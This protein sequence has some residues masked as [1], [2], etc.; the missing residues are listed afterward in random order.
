[1]AHSMNGDYGRNPQTELHPLHPQYQPPART[2]VSLHPGY[3]YSPELPPS[4]RTGASPLDTRAVTPPSLSPSGRQL[5]QF[6]QEIS[7]QRH[8]PNKNREIASIT[9][10]LNALSQ[11]HNP[12]FRVLLAEFHRLGLFPFSVKQLDLQHFPPTVKLQDIIKVRVQQRTVSQMRGK[13]Y[14][15]E[16]HVK[17]AIEWL[18]QIQDGETEQ[19]FEGARTIYAFREIAE[20]QDVLFADSISGNLAHRQTRTPSWQ[21]N[22]TPSSSPPAHQQE[23][24]LSVTTAQTGTTHQAQVTPARVEN[25]PPP[26]DRSSVITLKSNASGPVTIPY[27]DRTA[28]MASLAV[29]LIE[30]GHPLHSSKVINVGQNI[31]FGEP[32]KIRMDKA[33]H[34]YEANNGLQLVKRDGGP[35]SFPQALYAF[36]HFSARGEEGNRH[37]IFSPGVDNPDKLEQVLVTLL[38]QSRGERVLIND[39]QFTQIR[40]MV[41]EALEEIDRNDSLKE[42]RDLSRQYFQSVLICMDCHRIPG[43]RPVGRNRPNYSPRPAASPTPPRISP[44]PPRVSP[45]RTSVEA[46]Q[47]TFAPPR[48]EP[49]LEAEDYEQDVMPSLAFNT[50]ARDANERERHLPLGHR[51]R[52]IQAQRMEQF[53]GFSEKPKTHQC[54]VRTPTGETH[55]LKL[56]ERGP[57]AEIA[58]KMLQNNLCHLYSGRA[59][60]MGDDMSLVEGL[61]KRMGRGKNNIAV[62]GIVHLVKNEREAE[63]GHIFSQFFSAQI[64]DKETGEVQYLMPEGLRTPVQIEQRLLQIYEQM[65]GGVATVYADEFILMQSHLQEAKGYVAQARMSLEDKVLLDKYLDTLLSCLTIY[66]LPFIGHQRAFLDKHIRTMQNYR[67]Q[68]HDQMTSTELVGR[69]NQATLERNSDEANRCLYVLIQGMKF[70]LLTV[71]EL[72]QIMNNPHLPHQVQQ[73][74]RPLVT[75][76]AAQT[77][78]IHSLRVH[79]ARHNAR[80][81]SRT[82]LPPPMSMPQYGTNAPYG[83]RRPYERY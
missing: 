38:H 66:Q 4:D 76:H 11:Q 34:N 65:E 82:P 18:S 47:C 17:D 40:A 12:D 2:G 14:F 49:Q 52:G 7:A 46:P 24:L 1:M 28:P 19:L 10:C 79:T 13:E 48:V 26:I 54:Y 30:K 71:N 83:P 8:G 72:A 35:G 9:H 33:G 77:T 50:M 41:E 25:N 59:I 68:A 69:L 81:Q 20:K 43:Q 67:S 29:Q 23:P 37:Y 31:S 51:I 74:L 55:A 53:V 32:L 39:Q 21:E 5:L 42:Y 62:E 58:L 16:Y 64:T 78:G 27:F 61:N 75:L 70:N 22:K 56:S 44:P 73:S 63:L 57:V 36:I 15:D 45:P 3:R 60:Y 80:Q 6:M